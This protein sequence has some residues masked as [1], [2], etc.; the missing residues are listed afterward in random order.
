VAIQIKALKVTGSY[1]FFSIENL[2][3]L[4]RVND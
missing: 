2:V 3:E 4:Y 1:K